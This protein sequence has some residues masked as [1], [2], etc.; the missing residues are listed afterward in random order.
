MV[1]TRVLL[2]TIAFL[3]ANTVLAAVKTQ[4]GIGFGFLTPFNFDT[5]YSA[6]LKLDLIPDGT[7]HRLRIE[8]RYLNAQKENDDTYNNEFNEYVDA[9][10]LEMGPMFSLHKGETL[11]TF[12]GLGVSFTFA[13]IERSGEVYSYRDNSYTSYPVK[14]NDSGFGPGLSLYFQTEWKFTENIRYDF[15]AG[16]RF[17]TPHFKDEGVYVDGYRYDYGDDPSVGGFFANVGFLFA[18]NP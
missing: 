16:F 14:S 2:V 5:G 6:E 11:R 12:V 4:Y 9:F 7:P 1:K 8:A 17:G 10:T 3:M 15:G 18:L 13:N